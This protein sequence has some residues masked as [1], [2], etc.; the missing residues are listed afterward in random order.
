MLHHQGGFIQRASEIFANFFRDFP[1]FSVQRIRN[2][3]Q[4]VGTLQIP[5]PSL[6]NKS[7]A[8]KVEIWLMALLPSRSQT[9]SAIKSV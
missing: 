5:A 3:R 9:P 2:S 1:R 6:L 7:S 4:R 8:S